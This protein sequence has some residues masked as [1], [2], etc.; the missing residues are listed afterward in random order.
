VVAFAIRTSCLGYCRAVC[1][2]GTFVAP[3]FGV[4][5]V[6]RVGRAIVFAAGEI[7]VA[8]SFV[9]KAAEGAVFVRAGVNGV[10]G[11]VIGIL[12]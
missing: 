4:G 6:C 12:G 3:G 1:G 10:A 2:A 8:V 9:A 5:D 7:A 11:V